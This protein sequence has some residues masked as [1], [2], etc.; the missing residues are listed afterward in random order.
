M[1]ELHH[2][3]IIQF[4][5]EFRDSDCSYFL[6]EMLQGGDVLRLL[7]EYNRLPENWSRFY[8]GVVLLVFANIHEHNIVYR[9]LKP[10]NLV[11][12]SKGYPKVVDL[13]F[14]KKIEG[15]KLWTLCGTPDY[16]S[17]EVVTNEGH[18]SAVDYWSLGVLLL[19]LT[20]GTTPFASE[21]PMDVFKKIL[22][23]KIEI[24][25]FASDD[26]ADLV[27]KLLNPR[28]ATRIGSTYCGTKE[29]MDHI[30]F[31]NLNFEKLLQKRIDAPFVPTLSNKEDMRYFDDHSEYDI[32]HVRL[33]LF[34]LYFCY[35]FL[36]YFLIIF[37]STSGHWHIRGQKW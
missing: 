6:L 21:Y 10:E 16:M 13:E 2:P 9:N 26:L 33:V 12:D 30:W 31:S 15:G 24:P 32:R 20:S 27:V 8:S 3:F 34:T 29:V 36:K 4:Y 35:S 18:D 25:D 5:G 1:E 28:Q 11:L 14:A 37:Y 22:S 17:P 19:E 7:V 23:G